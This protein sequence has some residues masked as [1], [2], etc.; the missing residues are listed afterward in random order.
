MG[1]LKSTTLGTRHYKTRKP[2]PF[3]VQGTPQ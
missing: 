3:L 1:A 2:R